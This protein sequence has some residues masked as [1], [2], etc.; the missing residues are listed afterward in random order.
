MASEEPSLQ[1]LA[2]PK[3]S[4]C[5]CFPGSNYSKG[6]PL[7]PV[8]PLLSEFRCGECL[9]RSVDPLDSFRHIGLGVRG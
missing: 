2:T 7:F 9:D 1:A 6:I 4:C 5:S 3:C 8:R